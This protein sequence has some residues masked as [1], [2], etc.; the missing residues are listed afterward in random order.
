VLEPRFIEQIT[1]ADISAFIASRMTSRGLAPKTANHY[2]SILGRLFTWAADQRG[3]RL[4]GGVN[5]SLKVEKLRESAPE[6]VFL[7]LNQIE[8][9]FEALKDSPRLQ[10]AIATYIYAGLRRE[11][12]LWLTHDDIDWNAKQY[13]VIR[14]R[15][16]SIGE[17]SWQ[18]KTRSNRA[19]PIS[20]QLRPY[21]DKQR[22]RSSK[23]IWLFPNADNGRHDPDNFSAD[24]REA[25]KKAGPAWGCLHY[26]HTFGSHL[27]MKGESLFKIAK[28]MGNSPQIAERH[29]AAILPESL[30]TSVEFG[31]ARGRGA[32]QAGLQTCEAGPPPCA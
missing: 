14:V 24:L 19:V 23:S 17:E 4:P 7:N 32:G 28:L 25:N 6:I 13:G 9:Q 22:L 11:E 18:P 29:Y 26:R 8:Q 21:L 31:T 30:L 10:S 3:L 5:P 1:T 20:S 27:A 15:A 16:K 2:R 12:L